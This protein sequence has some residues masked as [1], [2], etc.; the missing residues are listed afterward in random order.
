[1]AYILQ[2]E[3]V[4]WTH[5]YVEPVAIHIFI[6]FLLTQYRDSGEVTGLS[7]HLYYIIN[8]KCDFLEIQKAYNGN[9]E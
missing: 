4:K 7:A 9:M 5:L 1:M 6:N 8:N 3:L 2:L